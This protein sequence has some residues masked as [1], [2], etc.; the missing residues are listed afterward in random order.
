[1]HHAARTLIAGIVALTLVACG[2]NSYSAIVRVPA[3]ELPA[4]GPKTFR[5][6]TS[7]PVWVKA[8][9][10]SMYSLTGPIERIELGMKPS[11]VPIALPFKAHI[12]GDEL[13]VLTDQERT[14]HV[15]DI[16]YAAVQYRNFTED[17]SA[18]RNKYVGA[19]LIIGSILPIGLGTYLLVD[20]SRRGG[21]GVNSSGG[22]GSTVQVVSVGLFSVGLLLVVAGLYLAFPDAKVPM[23]NR[24][25]LRRSPTPGTFSFEF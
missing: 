21:G 25:L 9:N 13:I 17:T 5:G 23:F 11:A 12:Q 6:S 24:M 8:I 3:S 1:M 16:S 22:L 10:G 2:P 18:T 19:G 7:L 15:P 14:Y 4:L 20:E